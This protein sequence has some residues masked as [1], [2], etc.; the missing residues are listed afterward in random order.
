MPAWLASVLAFLGSLV[1]LIPKP[2]PSAPI[3]EPVAPKAPAWG[4][5]DEAE[6]AE[7]RRRKGPIA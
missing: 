7:A 1:G 4:S 3:P 2:A 5:I 6:D